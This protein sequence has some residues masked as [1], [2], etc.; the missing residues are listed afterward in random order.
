MTDRELLER[1]ARAAGLNYE[2]M[3]GGYYTAPEFN[4]VVSWNPLTDD[5]DALRLAIRRRFHVKIF[6][7]W[8]DGSIDAP[9]RVE[10]WRWGDDDPIHTEYVKGSDYEAATRRAIVMAAAAMGEAK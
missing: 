4:E 6:S 8:Q 1:A 5:G 10:I 7:A 3:L 2:P 9:G